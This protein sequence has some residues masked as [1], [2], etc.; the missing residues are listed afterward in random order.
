MNIYINRSNP[1]YLYNIDLLNEIDILV[2]GKFDIS[3]K[4]SG[5]TFKESSNQRI[6]DAR[7]SLENGDTVIK[8]EYEERET[9]VWR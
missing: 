5:L 4:K 2:N 3:K 8:Y 1:F 9:D 6:I 7:K